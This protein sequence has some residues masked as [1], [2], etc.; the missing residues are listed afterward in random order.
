MPSEKFRRRLYGEVEQWRK[1]GLIDT[2]VYKQL[3]ERYQFA[4]L[5]N[6]AR[7]RFVLIL[8]SLGSI[9]LGLGIITFVAA[10]WQAWSRELKVI[11]LLSV[12]VGL[13]AV[14]FYLWRSPTQRWQRHLG[15]GLLLAGA[16]AL[17]ANLALMSQLFHQSSPLYQLFLAWGLGVLAMAYSLR[18]TL[19][20][21]LAIFFT[22]IGY[23]LGQGQ[24][25]FLD[26]GEFFWLRQIMEYMPVLAGLMFIPLAY[27]CHSRWIFRLAIL[28][29]VY[30]LEA[31]LIS[32]NL[33]RSPAWLAGIACALPPALLWAYNDSLW[34]KIVSIDES[35]KDTARTLA[36]T[37]LSLTLYLLSFYRLWDISSIPLTT[38]IS[39]LPWSSLVNILI[40]GCFTIWAWLQLWQRWDR[41]TSFVASMIALA[42]LIPY[43]HLSTVRLTVEAVLIFNLL[44]LI[45]AAGLVQ[46]GLAQGKRRLFWGGMVL[47]TLQIFTRMLEYQTDLL[48]KSLVLL[49]CGC[50]VIAAGL[51]FERYVRRRDAKLSRQ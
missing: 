38:G 23:V 28:L 20:G 32:L 46:E 19:L 50:G 8:L 25:E 13:N 7:N 9:L 12:F 24:A 3:Y 6:S 47:L 30:S 48:L 37:F 11:L 1:E 35:F 26:L 40:L 10:N 39:S 33:L 27:W 16:L 31:S 15:K 14:G 44:L 17:G 42:A 29:M 2:S 5:E 22:G 43:W 21:T 4:E 18:L 45:L 51:W 34:G 41:K 49:L 36:I